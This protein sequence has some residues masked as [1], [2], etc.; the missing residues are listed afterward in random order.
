MDPLFLWTIKGIPPNHPNAEQNRILQRNIKFMRETIAC[1]KNDLKG[2]EL[3]SGWNPSRLTRRIQLTSKRQVV[4]AKFQHLANLRI[5]VI[6]LHMD[7][8]LHLSTSC[9]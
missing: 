9:S 8:I 6:D 1:I 7:L 4:I 2:T 5:A 3:S